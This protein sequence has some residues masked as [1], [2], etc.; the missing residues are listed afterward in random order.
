[1]PGG[2]VCSGTMKQRRRRPIV[3]KRLLG[4]GRISSLFTKE[5][6][7]FFSEHAPEGIELDELSILGPIFVLKVRVTPQGPRAQARRRALALPGRFADRRAVDEVPAARGLR[8]RGR[9]ASFL[10]AR[11]MVPAEVQQTKTKKA[12]EFFSDRLREDGS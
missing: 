3:R 10:H 4:G 6:R 12:L 5:Q 2:F 1:M 8:R 7:A 11:D 9:A